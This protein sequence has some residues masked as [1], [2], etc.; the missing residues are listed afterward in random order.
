MQ[1]RKTTFIKGIGDHANNWFKHEQLSKYAD[2]LEDY[3]NTITD[4]DKAR[5]L[6]EYIR[7][8]RKNADKYNPLSFIL[9]E[10]GAISQED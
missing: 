9:L 6:R 7:L 8:V 10:M 3:T 5:L 2:E 4:E 1:A